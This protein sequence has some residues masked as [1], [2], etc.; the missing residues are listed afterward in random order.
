[1]STSTNVI[2]DI[3]KEFDDVFFDEASINRSTA[4]KIKAD[5]PRI[6]EK[7]KNSITKY[8]ANKTEEEK[9]QFSK[10]SSLAKKQL[11]I[12]RPEVIQQRIAQNKTQVNDIKYQEAL[13]AGAKKRNEDGSWKINLLRGQ[14]ERNKSETWKSNVKSGHE[15]RANNGTWKKNCFLAKAYPIVTPDG[16][17]KGLAEANIFYN[18][19]KKFNNGRRWLLEM[20]KKYPNLYYKI[21]WDE[22]E[23]KTGL[24]R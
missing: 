3:D 7:L 11:M 22:Y 16:I 20:M 12:D 6:K 23:E 15:K 9:K 19:L 13:R 5:D 17:H 8:H 10:T 18:N 21:S 14:E 4:N 1:M 2:I 24:K